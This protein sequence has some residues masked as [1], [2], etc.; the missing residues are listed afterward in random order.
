MCA[1][2]SLFACNITGVLDV[3]E[4]AA[5]AEIRWSPLVD[6]PPGEIEVTEIAVPG[7]LNLKLPLAA[8]VGATRISGTLIK[9][10][11]PFAELI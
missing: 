10:N 9:I 1:E 6:A 3:N 7:V 4:F 8:T 11:A 5:D 2:V